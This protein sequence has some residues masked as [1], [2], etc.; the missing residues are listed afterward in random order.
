[1]AR[2][3]KT[4]TEIRQD[5]TERIMN[6]IDERCG[7]YRANPQRFCEEFLNIHLKLFQKI[8]IWAMMHY[9]AFYFLASRGLGKTYLV[10]LFAVCRCILYPGSKIVCCSYTFKQGKE[11]I[12]KITDDFM[13]KSSLLRNEISRVSTGQNDCFVYFKNGSW[14]RV[15]V[16]GESSRGARS[17]ILIIDESRLVPQKIV[18]TILRPMNAAPRQPGYLRKPEYAHLSEM[19][20]EFYLSSAFYSAS[21]MYEKV[22]AYTANMLDPRLNY[23]VCDLPYMLSIKEGL[24]MRQQIINEMSEATFSDISFMMEREG[25]FYGS[26]DNA[27]FDY[28]TLEAQRIIGDCLFDLDYYRLTKAKMPEKKNEEVR[29]LSLDIALLASKRHNND[30]SAFVLHSGIPTSSNEY[31]DNIVNISPCEG[32]TTEELG[33]ETLRRFYQ[34]DCDYL[35]IDANGIGQAVLDYIMGADRYDPVYNETYG[36]LNVMNNSDLE[37]RCKVKNA[38]KVVYAIKA[39]ARSNNDMT[40]ALRAG[41]QNKYI[42][43]L[44]PDTNIEEKLSKIRGYGTLS[45]MQQASMRMPYVQTTLLI[46]ELINLT[47]DTSNGLIKVKEKSGMRKDRY[48]SLQYGYALL[49]ELSKGLKPKQNT[50]DLLSKLKIRPA[51]IVGR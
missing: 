46:N 22:K 39:N 49:Q 10:G 23:F 13:Q 20:K 2:N 11:I 12:L 7:Y 28:K 27:L 24:L 6:I 44:L 38:P 3:N 32:L 1:M 17:N 25:I 9:D 21:E 4:D 14:I 29:I 33:L 36:A 40:L 48:S 26:A 30:A 31:I 43:L 50:N 19:N 47:H 15:V 45:E 8:L 41:F 5:K 37:D 42:N 34:Y 51:K 18:D 35:A 16:A